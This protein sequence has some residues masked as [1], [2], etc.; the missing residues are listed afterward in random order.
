VETSGAATI[1]P[2]NGRQLGQEAE[3]VDER[4]RPSP[5]PPVA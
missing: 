4:D 1:D 5:D 2:D 3:W